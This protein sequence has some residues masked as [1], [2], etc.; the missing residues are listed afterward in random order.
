MTRFSQRAR[1]F[2]A[3]AV[4]L[5]A[6]A[7]TPAAALA[8]DASS[9]YECV[10]GHEVSSGLIAQ[11]RSRLQGSSAI[12]LASELESVG[13]IDSSSN[14]STSYVTNQPLGLSTTGSVRSVVIRVSFPASEDGSEQAMTFPESETDDDVLSAFNAPADASSELYPYESVHAY[15][16]RSSLGKLDMQ[17]TNAYS[18]TAQHS[19]SYYA[20]SDV[21]FDLFLETLKAL[22]DQIDFSQLDANDDGYIDAIYFEYAGPNGKWSTTW[23]PKMFSVL[24]ISGFSD[25]RL[26]GKLVDECV[27]F[28]TTGPA[29][30]SAYRTIIH[31][32]GHLLGLP[33]LY[34]N[35]D[36][37][38]KGTGTGSFDMMQDNTGEQNGFYK[39]LLGWLSPEDVTYVY[40]SENGVDVRRGDETT[41][42]E[43]SATLELTPYTS[44]VS[45]ETG[46]IVA[47]SSDKSI[48]EGNLFCTFFLL[49]FDR[50]AGNQTVTG[51]SG[52]MPLGHGVRAFRVMA[53]LN[54]AGNN[55][56][57]SNFKGQSGE[58]LYEVL[59]PQLEDSKKEFGAFMHEG[60]LVSPTTNPSTNTLN[61]EV[62]GY[63]GVTF[64]VVSET[65]ESA[66]VKFSWTK[67]SDVPQFS[68]SL[69]ESAVANG[70]NYLKLKTSWP[71]T[72]L[73]YSDDAIYVEVDGEKH[74]TSYDYDS[75]TGELTMEAYFNP[76]TITASSKVEIVASKGTFNLGVDESGAQVASDELRVPLGVADLATIDEA[77]NY[78]T[79]S[80]SGLDECVMSN[81]AAD[82]SGRAYFFV[83]CADQKTYVHQ[84]RL[85][86]LSED[87][88]SAETVA[89][90]R[91]AIC[92]DN[93]GA[94]MMVTDLGDGTAVLS[95]SWMSDE[96]SVSSIRRNAWIDLS[97]GKVLAIRDSSDLKYPN[98]FF[99]L[100]GDLA[101]ATLVNRGSSAVVT[102]YR[103]E[104][105]TV[106]QLDGI[107]LPKSADVSQFN[108]AGEAGND[109]VYTIGCADGD[110]DTY[111]VSIYRK[112][113]VLSAGADAA[114]VAKVSIP[115]CVLV[116]DVE[117]S[118]DKVY[119]ASRNATDGG[120]TNQLL[121][122]SLDGDLLATASLPT[123]ISYAAQ[124]EVSDNG[125]VACTS[126]KMSIE[127]KKKNYF[128][129]VALYDPT[130]C[131][132]SEIDVRGIATGTWVGNRWL[133][134][135]R[136]EA[137]KF[138]EQA[139]VMTLRWSLTKEFGT[140]GGDDDPEPEPTPDPS[141]EPTPDSG[142]PTTPSQASD[143]QTARTSKAATLPKTGDDAPLLAAALL[144]GGA[145]AL[146]AR[147][148]LG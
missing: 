58:Q 19:R 64:E 139:A 112:A 54:S 88:R 20:N 37:N 96:A 146:I 52:D 100:G 123:Y 147:R 67:K 143:Q 55:F 130:T 41:H 46:G 122:Y 134:V 108:G 40:T 7:L 5:V 92:G 34:A 32:T 103:R 81:M 3:V 57:Y 45:T 80:F 18:Y 10:G 9:T 62:R 59:D 74:K 56:I 95:S 97:T 50:Y 86:R 65:D 132:V 104:G 133:E 12:S 84:L 125:A 115:N 76:G 85:V 21:P 51:G 28:S 77:G 107:A 27:M 15:Y 68:M 25:L 26:D 106:T 38:P 141:P 116:A 79:F 128:G 136:D 43:D 114:S 60:A 22:D 127:N 73:N 4:L 121:T 83:A 33:D 138:R 39:W 120:Y 148:R 75:S 91:S 89:V 30:R 6:T 71:A 137:A 23:W 31:E 29:A 11:A 48:L 82:P 126:F 87:G 129:Y 135:T 24:T 69:T 94:L 16:E 117:L 35:P 36:E 145:L 101:R 61:S 144:G 72:L 140:A 13:D 47:V 111:V 110:A 99:M 142:S 124:L 131:E 98:S 105:N 66:Q 17:A 44:N 113:D 42:Y 119:V 53:K 14:G 63:T 93:N 70:A 78:D 118:D 109:C 8:E 90:D 102:R 2:A 49:Q 1:R